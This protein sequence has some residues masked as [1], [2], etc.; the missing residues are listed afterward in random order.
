MSFTKMSARWACL[1]SL[2]IVTRA[3]PARIVS[4]ALIMRTSDPTQQSRRENMKAQKEKAR[5]VM[6]SCEAHSLG[7]SPAFFRF[8]LPPGA[9]I[10]DV[11]ANDGSDYAIPASI[12][13]GTVYAF[14]PVLRTVER[15]EE[16]ARSSNVPLSK[17]AAADPQEIINLAANSNSHQGVATHVAT[18]RLV[19]VAA[20]ASNASGVAVMTVQQTPRSTGSALLASNV[21][22]NSPK[23]VIT[24]RIPLVRID[25]VVTSDVLLLKIDAQGHEHAALLGARGLFAARRVRFVT[26]ELSPKMLARSRRARGGGGGSGGGGGG[27]SGGDEAAAAVEVLDL[28]RAAGFLCFQSPVVNS[29]MVPKERASSFEGFVGAHLAGFPAAARGGRSLEQCRPGTP[30]FDA[31]TGTGKWTELVCAH[32]ALHGGVAGAV[33]GLL[34]VMG[35]DAA[36]DAAEI[37]AIV[38]EARSLAPPL[39]HAPL[40][41]LAVARRPGLGL[42]SAKAPRRCPACPT[43]VCSSQ[44]LFLRSA[45]SQ[46]VNETTLFAPESGSALGAPPSGPQSR[47]GARKQCDLRSLEATMRKE[48]PAARP[49]RRG[50]KPFKALSRPGGGSSVAGPAASSQPPPPGGRGSSYLP[51]GALLLTIASWVLLLLLLMS[52]GCR[53]HSSKFKCLS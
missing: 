15:L 47:A 37:D 39:A 51:A 42:G 50:S 11:G 49:N 14:E 16:L 20:A 31:P 23:D 5:A 22:T 28:L 9:T 26:F 17:L 33:R 25:D 34:D 21:R 43:P 45:P 2:V 19:V 24:A 13:G 3:L 46:V 52:C 38:L 44:N 10:V 36:A 12:C 7:D 8:E 6:A 30:C 29:R 40:V 41:P 53:L 27:G 32:V 1:V 48:E 4:R 35:C 18:T